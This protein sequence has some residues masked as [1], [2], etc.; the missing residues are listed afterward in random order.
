VQRAPRP[1]LRAEIPRRVGL[2]EAAPDT[3]FTI[4]ANNRVLW[5]GVEIARL[6][7]G[8]SL[9]RPHLEVMDS[10]FLD[11]PQRE[12][13]RRRLVDYCTTLI[14]H[15]LAPLQRAI[16]ACDADPI[17]RGPL[18]RLA[19]AGGV[20]AG[21]TEESIPPELRGRLKKLGVQA[22]RFAL[23]MPALL[24]P[25]PAAVRAMLWAIRHR[26][27]TP[28]LPGPGLV[29]VPTDKA[30]AC[31][32]ELGWVAAGPVLIRLD[33]AERIA[34]ELAWLTRA[35]P[36]SLPLDLAPRLGIRADLLP[37]VLRALGLR[38]LPAPALGEAE[39]GPPSPPLIGSPRKRAIVPQREV[40][41]EGPFAALASWRR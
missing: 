19:E 5:D 28:P 23:F 30:H 36:A 17:L 34:A 37:P 32:P 16:A 24:K 1:P 21:A 33:V 6:V 11:G 39:Y 2:L 7:P 18:H 27:A 35:R 31:L 40:A 41:T 22:G 14:S 9:L 29:S 13:I 26:V 15:E 38:L 10:E 4:G 12:R 3:D 25:R 20:V 8:R